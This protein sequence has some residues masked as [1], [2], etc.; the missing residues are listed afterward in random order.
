MS[1]ARAVPVL[2]AAAA[3]GLDARRPLAARVACAAPAAAVSAPAAPAAP[4]S[5]WQDSARGP[6][7]KPVYPRA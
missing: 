2:G 4:L 7:G 6:A 3:S 1:D 5:E